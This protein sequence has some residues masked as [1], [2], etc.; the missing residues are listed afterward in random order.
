MKATIVRTPVAIKAL[1]DNYVWVLHDTSN[2][3]CAVVDPGEARCCFA[4]PNS[5]STCA[6]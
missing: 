5:T 1:R 6:Y 2:R 4:I 3:Y